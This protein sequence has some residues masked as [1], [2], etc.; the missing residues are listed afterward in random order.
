MIKRF[1]LNEL[2]KYLINSG[3]VPGGFF[4][5]LNILFNKDGHIV[6]VTLKHKQ[7]LEPV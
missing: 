6:D 4:G 7:L 1:V 2:A 5:E 3:V